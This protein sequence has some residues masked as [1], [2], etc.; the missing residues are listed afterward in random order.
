M[1]GRG[2]EWDKINEVI[3]HTH[4]TCMQ[5]QTTT[6]HTHTHTHTHTQQTKGF[7]VSYKSRD[8]DINHVN[9]V[10][11][12]HLVYHVI[13]FATDINHVIYINA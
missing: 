12:G 6:T 13:F 8:L 2:Q 5:T 4:T 3:T 10:C 7:I 11:N 1:C 9:Y